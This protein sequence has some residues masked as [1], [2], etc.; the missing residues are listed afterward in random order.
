MKIPAQKEIFERVHD[1]YE[2]HYYDPQ[3]TH[4]RRQFICDPLFHDLNMNNWAVADVASG[5]GH[6]SL[7]LRERFPE[8][9]TTGF[10]ISR[11]ACEAYRELVGRDALEVDL[12]KVYDGE[13][14]FDS[15]VIIGGL[16]H[17]LT[18]LPMALRNIAGMLKPNGWFLMMEPNRECFLDLARRVWYRLDSANFDADTESALVHNEVLRLAGTNFRLNDV[19][20]LGGP[21]YFLILQSMHLGVSPKIKRNIAPALFVVERLYNRIPG[22]YW[23]P[24]FVARWRKGAEA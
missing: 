12:T 22:R 24:Y 16:H 13:D 4:Y 11:K 6:N 20:F 14:K 3:S 9:L 5:S 15:V 8:V 7:A 17:C 18:D 10:D 19:S 23:F 21:A 1:E 2:R